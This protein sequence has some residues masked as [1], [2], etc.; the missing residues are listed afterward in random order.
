M[1]GEVKKLMLII[2][3]FSISA[4]FSDEPELVL[5]LAGEISVEMFATPG[6]PGGDVFQLAVARLV[7]T[8]PFPVEISWG[9]LKQDPNGRFCV[10]VEGYRLDGITPQVVTT[11]SQS[12]ELGIFERGNYKATLKSGGEIL[13]KDEFFVNGGGNMDLVNGLPSR[14]AIDIVQLP[15]RGL[16]PTFAANI[17][18]TF[19]Q[20]VDHVDW[21]DVSRKENRVESEMTAWIDPSVRILTPM[22]VEEQI[23]LGMFFPGNYHYQLSSLKEV[24]SGASISVAGPQRDFS[25]PKITVRGASV[26][27]VSDEPLEFSV[28]FFDDGELVFD[29]VETQVLSVINRKGEVVELERTSIQECIRR[30][31]H[32][33]Y[34]VRRGVRTS[35][36]H[37][38]EDVRGESAHAVH[39]VDKLGTVRHS[40][41]LR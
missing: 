8:F 34:G 30:K 1:I 24:I 38:L 20:Y 31:S 33:G 3:A 28:E 39:E 35:L 2:L 27:R 26:T 5:P 16:Y 11:Y 10:E 17:Q 7:V 12:V 18:M 29:G 41:L 36:G 13:G 6:V 25:P 40:I 4:G 37:Q 15:T 21:G 22:I 19:D 9:K 14:V 23:A 32:S